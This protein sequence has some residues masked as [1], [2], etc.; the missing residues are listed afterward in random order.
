M[1]YELSGHKTSVVAQDDNGQVW[2]GR[3][4]D[5]GLFMGNDPKTHTWALTDVLRDLLLNVEFKK[6][7]RRCTARRP[8]PGSSASSR[9]ED[10][11]LLHLGRH[12]V[13]RHARRGGDRRLLGK[14]DDCQFLTFE[15]RL[16]IEADHDAAKYTHAVRP[17]VHACC[18][19]TTRSARAYIIAGAQS[20]E[21]GVRAQITVQR[22]RR[23]AHEPM[24]QRRR[25]ARCTEA[26]SDGSFA[27]GALQTNYDRSRPPGFDDRRYPDG[28]LPRCARPE[29][30]HAGRGLVLPCDVGDADAPGRARSS[31]RT[32]T[33][34]A[35]S[36]TACPYGPTCAPF[37]PRPARIV[38]VRE[39]ESY[40]ANAA[41][42]HVRNDGREAH[43]RAD[44]PRARSNP[45]IG[46]RPNL[47]F[48]APPS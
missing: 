38:E 42:R 36:R 5:F 17:G 46:A 30:A 44:R 43:A 2:H 31:P 28:E 37:T 22:H 48:I 4:L 15:T 32:H 13:R 29:E 40:A 8:T 34:R 18:A 23:A 6:G 41:Q 33:R 47:A 27:H 14:N 39:R 20:G 11:R 12:A 24:R 7:G 9:A 16:A 26:L 45:S 19:T 3:N 10:G 35:S 1:M 21:G 25:A